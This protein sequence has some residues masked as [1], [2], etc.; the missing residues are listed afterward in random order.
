MGLIG[1]I[2]IKGQALTKKEKEYL[3]KL[4]IVNIYEKYK[5]GL[6]EFG[7]LETLN[8]KLISLADYNKQYEYSYNELQGIRRT[9][10]FIL[11]NHNYKH[12]NLCLTELNRAYSDLLFKLNESSIIPTETEADREKYFRNSVKIG[13]YIAYLYDLK[14]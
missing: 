7:D 9:V 1:E 13:R 2:N 6:R 10:S 4:D 14:Q 12:L 5:G 11:S 3:S 8:T